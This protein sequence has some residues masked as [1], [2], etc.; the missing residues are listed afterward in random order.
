MNTEEKTE[1]Y[2][3]IFFCGVFGIMIF[4]LAFLT[5][6]FTEIPVAACMITAILLMIF[7]TMS[8]FIE[9]EKVRTVFATLGFI[10]Y[11]SGL[12]FAI[13]AFLSRAFGTSFDIA[14][15]TAAVVSAA[16]SGMCLASLRNN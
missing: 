10:G 2:Q 13:S 12:I 14:M 8:C 1:I 4:L 5:A 15:I 9:K 16:T 11:M 6:K 3:R 7:T